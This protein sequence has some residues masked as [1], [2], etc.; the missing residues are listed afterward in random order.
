[1]QTE[2]CSALFIAMVGHDLNLLDYSMTVYYC[3]IKITNLCTCNLLA[4]TRGH[5]I[6]NTG[7]VQ[8]TTIDYLHGKEYAKTPCELDLV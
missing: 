3:P 1:M 7:Y 2:C 6:R 4:A 8:K 5:T